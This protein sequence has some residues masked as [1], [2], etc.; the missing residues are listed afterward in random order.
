MFSEKMPWGG[1]HWRVERGSHGCCCCWRWEGGFWGRVLWRGASWLP[2]V[3]WHCFP[4]SWELSSSNQRAVLVKSVRFSRQLER[5]ELFFQ[6]TFFQTFSNYFCWKSVF[7]VYS[8]QL[9]IF[10]NISISIGFGLFLF[11][12]NRYW[13]YFIR[14]QSVLV[15]FC[16]VSIGFHCFFIGFNRLSL[17]IPWLFFWIFTRGC[18]VP[19]PRFSK[20][21]R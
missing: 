20:L 8:Y 13:L 14:F 3:Q 2:C 9:I 10:L 17:I 15:S 16:F 18:R 1:S 19:Y 4:T 12:F 5:R 21:F 6:M 7:R 11:D